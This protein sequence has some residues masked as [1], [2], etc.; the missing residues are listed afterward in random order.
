MTNW[1][2]MI[3]DLEGLGWSLTGLARAIGLSPQAVSD[4]KQGRT[5][6]PGGMAAV[7][8]YELHS[9]GEGPSA[10]PEREAAA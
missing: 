2:R 7:R 10:R 9:R 6:A 8:L 4:I 1:K 3:L 5:K